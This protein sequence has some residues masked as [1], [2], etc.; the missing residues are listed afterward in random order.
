MKKT[1]LF[2]QMRDGGSFAR[3]RRMQIFS[4]SVNPKT[5]AQSAVDSFPSLF[6][7]QML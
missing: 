4:H 5:T 1:L 7:S 3:V 2:Q 6:A